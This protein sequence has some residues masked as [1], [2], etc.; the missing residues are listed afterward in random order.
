MNKLWQE[1]L[2]P[3]GNDDPVWELFHENSKTRRYDASLSNEEIHA[4]MKDLHESLPFVGYP[5]IE[6]PSSLMPLTS[7]LDEVIS[8]RISALNMD[9][10][11]FTMRELGT[12]LHYAYGITRDNNGTS[13]PRPFRTVPSAGALYPLE[14]FFHSTRIEG[15]NPG[16]Y[17]YNATQNNLRLL[18]AGDETPR[19]SGAMVQSEV[20][21]RASLII[22]ITAIFERTIFKYRDRG[23]RFVMLEAGHVAQNITLVAH[24]MGLGCLNIGGYFDREI[25]DFLDFDGITQ[26]TV[27]MGALGK[28]I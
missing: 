9:A 24:A 15:L 3:R 4:R 18:R 1:R 11:V 21:S 14:I 6:L 22:F 19:I 8:S 23:Y 12:L 17:H 26:S 13:S 5:V 2:L 7:C 27:Y 20:V 10:Y 16:L 25:D 28:A